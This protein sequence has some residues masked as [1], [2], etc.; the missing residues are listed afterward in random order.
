VH[1][2]DFFSCH[3][4]ADDDVEE[5]K[6]QAFN[7]LQKCRNKKGEYLLTPL[8]D[9]SPFTQTFAIFLLHFLGKLNKESVNYDEVSISLVEGLYKYKKER[10]SVKKIDRDKY[11]M[12]LFSFV[13]SALYLLN[14]TKEYPLEELIVQL[15]PDDMEQYLKEVGSFQG[16]SQSG[17]LAMCMG[18][19]SIYARDVLKKDTQI[20]VNDWVVSHLEAM[21]DNGFW[22]E[23][24][25]THLQFQN[26]YHQYE[27]FEYLAVHNHGAKNAANLVRKTSDIRGQYAPYFGGSGCY[28]YDAV[29]ILTAPELSLSDKNKTLLIKTGNTILSERNSDGGFSESQ[30]RRPLT[31]KS[32]FYG[33][34]HVVGVSGDLRKERARYFASML[35]PKNNRLDTHWTKHSRQ[36]SESNLWDTWFR[37]LT[38]ARIDIALDCKNSKRWGFI[39]F[40]GIGFHH[41]MV[42]DTK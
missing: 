34:R 35:L 33:V 32:L 6:F 18:V 13:L 16:V 30:W 24:K 25:T 5:L 28:D 29:A 15:L 39:D 4:L 7:F 26:G 9:S 10:E 23:G 22:G 19:F 40:P 2:T 12:Q 17:N 27:I 11:F 1:S 14:K 21:N 20:L 42:D 8:S 31:I 3:G 41:F 38:I 37:L 36:W